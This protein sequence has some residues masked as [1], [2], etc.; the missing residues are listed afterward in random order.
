[1]WLNRMNICRR[2]GGFTSY[3]FEI[4]NA[5]KPGESNTLADR[6]RQITRDYLFDANDDWPLGDA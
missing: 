3:A 6:V 1:M 2:D 4:Q 5:I